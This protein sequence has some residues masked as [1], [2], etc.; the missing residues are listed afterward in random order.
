MFDFASASD[1]ET[2][3]SKHSLALST[4]LDSPSAFVAKPK[5]IATSEIFLR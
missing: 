1:A 5:P 4:A 2:S 3:F